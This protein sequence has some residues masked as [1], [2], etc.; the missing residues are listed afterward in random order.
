[1]LAVHLIDQPLY[2]APGA[3]LVPI[4]PLTPDPARGLMEVAHRE[5]AD[6]IVT[7][8]RGRGGFAELLLGSTSHALTHHAA[9]PIVI[10]P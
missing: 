3:T 2:V 10:V 7:G 4:P 8:R 5:N 9:L 6:L 1:V